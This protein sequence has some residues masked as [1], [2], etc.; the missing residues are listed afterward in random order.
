VT[1]HKVVAARFTEGAHCATCGAT[2]LVGGGYR[3]GEGD[4]HGVSNSGE[5]LRVLIEAHKD[6][7]GVEILRPA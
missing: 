3:D 4:V 5:A 7:S 2:V 6:E 1:A